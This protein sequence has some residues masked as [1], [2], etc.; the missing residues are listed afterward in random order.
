MSSSPQPKASLLKHFLKGSFYRPR[1]ASLLSSPPSF[2]L[3]RH[4]YADT[5]DDAPGITPDR[6]KNAWGVAW[7]G[8]ETALRLLESCAC[9]CPPLKSVISGLVACLD[10]AQVSYFFIDLTY[11]KVSDYT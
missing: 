3:S 6:R 2:T 8:L 1:N 5:P 4:N 11:F 9:T 10:L 7:N